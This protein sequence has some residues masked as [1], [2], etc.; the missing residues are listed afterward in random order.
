MRKLEV[1]SFVLAAISFAF[2]LFDQGAAVPV[3][4]FYFLL[5]ATV[6]FVIGFGALVVRYAKAVAPEW[7]DD[8]G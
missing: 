1:I 5:A 4:N 8:N 3:Q 7:N 2:W 6:F